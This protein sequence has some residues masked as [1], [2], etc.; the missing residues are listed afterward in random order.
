MV[1]EAIEFLQ[2]ESA[3]LEANH[4]VKIVRGSGDAKH[5]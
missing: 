1:F 5:G 4:G 2:T 3:L